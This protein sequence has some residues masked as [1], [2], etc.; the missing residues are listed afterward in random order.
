MLG[1]L[2]LNRIG[3]HVDDADVVTIHQRCSAKRGVDPVQQLT[4]PHSLSNT[5]GHG[6]ILSLG[7]GSGD[8]VLTLGGLGDEV[9]AEKHSIA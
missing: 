9:V 3:G 1:S 2:M 5:I 6:A 4:Q 7:A 8:S